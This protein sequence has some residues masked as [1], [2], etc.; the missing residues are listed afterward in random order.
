MLQHRHVQEFCLGS[1]A[2]KEALI[3]NNASLKDLYA[4]TYSQAERLFLS[5]AYNP[6]RVLFQTLLIRTA[7]DWI[8]SH[9][10]EPQDFESFYNSTQWH[11]CSSYRKKIYLQPIDVDEVRQGAR[12]LFLDD[13]KSYL[14]AF[15]LG[16][17]VVSL[18]P[19]STSSIKCRFRQ[20]IHLNKIQLHT[21]AI[22]RHLRRVKP[23]DAF[24]VLGLTFMDIYPCDTW[25]YTFGKSEN[26]LAVGVCSFSRLCGI[27]LGEGSGMA[28]RAAAAME[29]KDDSRDRRAQSEQ[30]R[31]LTLTDLLQCC[32]VASH[33]LCHLVGLQNCRW[34][35]CVMQ[36]VASVDEV[37]LRPMDLCPICLRKLHC[38]L[39]FSLLQRYQKLQAWCHCVALSRAPRERVGRAQSSEDGCCLFSSDSEGS[40][41]N[42]SQPRSATQELHSLKDSVFQARQQGGCSGTSASLCPS[43]SSRTQEKGPAAALRPELC[44]D[45]LGDYEAWLGSCMGTLQRKA[46]EDEPAQLDRLVDSMPAPITSLTRAPSL[47]VLPEPHGEEQHHFG[48]AIRQRFVQMWRKLSSRQ[49]QQTAG[50]TRAKTDRPTVSPD[51]EPS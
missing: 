4:R 49:P 18:P 33:E 1:Q 37:F 16:F 36:G 15:F 7:F 51:S 22:L 12:M 2:L 45:T 35:H 31:A 41:E 34:L 48:G 43:V 27:P 25:N 28:E 10:E 39:G 9:P 19:I 8:V 23:M 30:P 21:D 50:L 20:Q 40:C 6:D 13:L 26:D 11:H 38:A 29:E 32:K 14:E 42:P 44:P 47:R 24:C 3:S 5:E 46:P 17:R